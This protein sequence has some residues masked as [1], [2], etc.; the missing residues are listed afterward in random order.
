MESLIGLMDYIL[1][2]FYEN[3]GSKRLADY[4]LIVDLS[5]T[6]LFYLFGGLCQLV[7]KAIRT[8]AFQ[9]NELLKFL[10]PSPVSCLI[11]PLAYFQGSLCW[12][13]AGQLSGYYVQTFGI[14]VT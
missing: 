2:Y 7:K 8:K 3:E 9:K 14:V 12:A 13:E 5:F 11:L 1:Y 4:S 10:S 6:V